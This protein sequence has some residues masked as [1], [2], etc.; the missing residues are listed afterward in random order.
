MLLIDIGIE[1][2]ALKLQQRP[3]LRHIEF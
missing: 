2:M 1:K 3:I